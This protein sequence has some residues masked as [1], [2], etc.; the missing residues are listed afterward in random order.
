VV[1]IKR[2]KWE[3]QKRNINGGYAVV[4]SRTQIPLAVAHAF[5]VHRTLGITLHAA[6]VSNMNILSKR[7]Y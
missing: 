4:A 1:E 5:S 7:S 2:Q 3:V 6:I